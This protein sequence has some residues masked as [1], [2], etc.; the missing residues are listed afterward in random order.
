M[1]KN[2]FLM[3]VST[4]LLVLLVCTNAFSQID[5]S[6]KPGWNPRGTVSLNLSQ[7]SFS[8]WTQGGDNS[9]SFASLG[10]F[11]VYYIHK[12]WDVS[13]KLKIAYGRAKTNDNYFTTDN[14][15]RFETVVIKKLGW[16]L[17]PYASNEVR[18]SLA[19]GFDYKTNPATQIVAF[20]DPGY[21][22]QSLGFIYAQKYIS[23]RLGIG[24]QEVFT[25][26]F[27]R[28]SA[29][30]DNPAEIK[31]FKFD[32][33]IESVTETNFEFMK[34]MM[35]TGR[36][37]LFSRFNS[38]DVWDVNFDNLIGAKVN[39]YISVNFGVNVIYEKS[40]S[41]KTQVKEA[42]QIGFSYVLF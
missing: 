7:M 23:T 4:L 2:Y 26:K 40:Q 30:P 13:N 20:F 39:D 25:N 32:S 42:L 11:G 5:T 24:F 3:Q 12:Q 6:M 15:L 34:N 29:D 16:K 18:T 19:N 31:K 9:M 8:N 21:L 35:Y 33:G 36:L 37:R 22:T 27:N 38:I 28:Y 41:M 10:N 14:E 1:K 17:N